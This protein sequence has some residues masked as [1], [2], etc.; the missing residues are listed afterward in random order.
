[1]HKSGMISI[2]FFIGL[3]LVAYG[4]IITGAGIHDVMVPP[5]HAPVLS[6]LHAGVWWGGFLLAIGLFYTI[7]F[8]PSRMK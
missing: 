1:M 3:L 4:L 8:R 7:Y 2:W 6:N 5:E